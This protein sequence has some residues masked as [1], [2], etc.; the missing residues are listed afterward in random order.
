MKIQLYFQ[1]LHFW[2][3]VWLNSKTTLIIMSR[4]EQ[5]VLA[6]QKA[7][8]ICPGDGAPIEKHQ[9]MA[10]NPFRFFRGAAGLFYDDIAAGILSIPEDLNAHLPITTVQGDCHLS[11]FGFLTEEGSHGDKVIFSPNGFDD[12]CL[13]YASWDLV[14]FGVS[15]LLAQDYCEGIVR[16]EFS[17]E[18]IDSIEGLQ[19]TSAEGAIV[20]IQGFVQS[21]IEQCQVLLGDDKA[22]HKVVNKFDKAHA[23]YPFCKKAKK[24]AS[25][26]KQF[27]SKSA[28]AKAVD[29]TGFVPV[30]DLSSD[31]FEAL[32]DALYREIFE[33][34]SPYVDD[35]ILD[36]TRRLGA[37]TGSINMDR[38]YLLVGPQ[39]YMDEE[40]LQLC[41]IVEVK[42]QR[43]AAPLTH[44]ETLSPVNRL[45]P[46]HLTVSCQRRMQRKPDLVLDEVEWRDS[47]WLVRSRHHSKVGIDPEDICI[48]SASPDEALLQYVQSCGQA[49]AIAHSRG[50][51]RSTRFEQA[52]CEYLPE[53][54]DDILDVCLT[55]AVQV[56]EDTQILRALNNPND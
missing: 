3:K 37:G 35:N 52:V 54:A 34:F 33:V 43:M 15:I 11:N 42:E 51:R 4:E 14:R 31:K 44:F 48:L 13:G 22:R 24:R 40:D 49:L 16:G 18:E 8:G 45:N 17:S 56:Q 30:F 46:A 26:G 23:L 41:H 53:H 39:D 36:I 38:F 29:L 5:I 25:G 12:A 2:F 7:D 9:K 47:H 20:A 55:Y 6:L 27:Y 10:A 21:Y 1:I 28:L 32:D 19:A 50:D